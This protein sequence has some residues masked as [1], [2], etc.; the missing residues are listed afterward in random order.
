VTAFGSGLAISRTAKNPDAAFKAIDFLTSTEAQQKIIATGQDV[1]ASVEVQKSE[2]FLK[3]SWMTKPVNMDVFAESS[4]FVYR[5]PFIPAWNEM[6]K[7][8]D[9]GLADFW[10]GKKDARTALTSIQQRLESIV[11]PAG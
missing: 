5:A 10:L 11:K 3:P 1:P 8:F 9:D 6:Q 7:A 2:A 4:S